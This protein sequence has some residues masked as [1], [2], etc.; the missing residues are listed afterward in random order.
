[1]ARHRVTIGFGNSNGRSKRSRAASVAVI[2]VAGVVAALA[3]PG[4]SGAAGATGRSPV[5]RAHAVAV[6]PGI[7]VAG[8]HYSRLV[9]LCAP[10]KPGTNAC[11]AIRSVSVSV[12]PGSRLP[13][14]VQADVGGN[15]PAGGYS[16]ADLES[17]YHFSRTSGGKGQTIGIVDWFDDPRAL[18]DLDTFDAHYG[19]PAETAKS[20]RKVNEHG[21]AAPLPPASATDQGN[22]DSTPE[23]SLDIQSA[24]AVC[25]HCRIVLIE[26]QSPLNTDLATA[27]NTAVRLGANEVSNSFGGGEDTRKSAAKSE[28]KFAKAFNHKGVVITAS[29]GDNGWYSW[30][31]ANESGG[32]SFNVANTPSTF[33]TV[34][35]VGGTKLVDTGKRAKPVRKSESVWNENGPHDSVGVPH[36]PQ[37]ASGGGCSQ[38]FKAKRWQHKV[39]GYSKT[40]CGKKRLAADVSAVADPRTGFDVFDSDDGLDWFTVGGTSLSSPVVASM[41]ALAGGAHKVAYPALTLYGN[42]KTHRARLHDVTAGGNGFCDGSGPAACKNEFSPPRSPNTFGLG[43]LDCGFKANSAKVVAANHQCEAAKGYDGPSGVGTPNGLKVFSRL[44]PS[45][46]IHK[47][48]AHRGHEVKFGAKVHDPFPGGGIARYTWT[49]GDGQHS[50]KAHP[51]HVYSKAKKYTVTLVVTDVYGLKHS[52]H[53]KIH[54]KH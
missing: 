3:L 26:A 52:A 17:L 11:F 45:A 12:K 40:G 22:S 9:P 13:A 25:A 14:G 24:R 15:G 46:H 48:S 18:A 10:P 5:L 50:H 1:M 34:V 20:F 27:E 23:I 21:K 53:R 30:D 41:W 36:G 7:A 35:A 44:S 6:T 29:T 31:F 51:T 16:P 43:L 37:G 42:Q 32:G 54:V 19:F 28:R 8:G 2:A 4:T 49:F 38:L 47:I 39:A 33:P